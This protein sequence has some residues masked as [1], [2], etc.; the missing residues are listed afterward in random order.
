MTATI[1]VRLK[2]ANYTIAIGTNLIGG[3][4]DALSLLNFPRKI[5]LISNQ[6]ISDF[7]GSAVSDSLRACGF[8]VYPYNVGDGESFKTADSLHTIYNF[9]IENGFD[10]GCGLIALGGGVVGDMAGFAAATFMRGIPYA[11]I[12]TTLLAQVDS[13]VGG[14]TAINHPLGKNLIGAFYQPKYVLIDI[15]VLG[16]L[17]GIE[18][19]A[20]LAEV[21]KYGMIKDKVFFSWLELNCD[22]LKK[23]DHSALIHAIKTSC[24]IKADIVALDEK[25]GSVRAILNYG[26]TFGHA[27][28]NLSGYGAWKHGEAVAVGMVIASKVSLSKGLCSQQDVDRLIDLLKRFDLPVE[29]P[30]FPLQDYV[31]SMARDKKVKNGELMMV[32]NRGIGDVVLQPISNIEDV[33]SIIL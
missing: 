9:L 5:A 28:E 2:H 4:G 31:E 21:V 24:K 17:D 25:E 16:T 30:E 18:V 11:Q 1:D 22:K 8:S 15:A 32:L 10:R 23:L 26:H 29:P 27:I 33:F 20:G 14:K 19:S 6:L 3:V 12:P 13:S 7:Y